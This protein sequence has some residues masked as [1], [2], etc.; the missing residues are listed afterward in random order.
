MR[1]LIS[2]LGLAVIVGTGYFA[3]AQYVDVAH[4]Q[5][6]MLVADQ[7]TI[8]ANSTGAQV[9][10][11]LNRLKQINLDGKIFS[12]PNFATLQDWSVAIDPQTVGRANPYLPAYGA[13]AASSSARVPLPRR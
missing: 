11:L 13:A 9:L 12:D 5:T 2:I 8:N 10:A 4:G 7:T 3:V 6:D 1:Y